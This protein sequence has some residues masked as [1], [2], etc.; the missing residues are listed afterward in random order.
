MTADSWNQVANEVQDAEQPVT[1]VISHRVKR[2]RESE[3]ERWL[4]DVSAVAQQFEG[5]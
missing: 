5:H 4:H 2:G 3:Y 1:A